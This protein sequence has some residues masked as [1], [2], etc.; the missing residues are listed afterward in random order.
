MQQLSPIGRSVIEHF[1]RQRTRLPD[2]FHLDVSPEDEMY[3]YHVSDAPLGD[4]DDWLLNYFESGSMMIEELRPIFNHV[5]GGF[6]KIGSLLEFACGHGRFTRYLVQELAPERIS[7]S[8]IYTDAVEFQ[9][10]EFGVRGIVSA[11]E[12][13]EF[14]DDHRYECILVC[15]L[16]SHLPE[17]TFHLWLEKLLSLLTDD[18]FLIFT[19]H[20]EAVGP[21][22]LKNKPAKDKPRITFSPISESRSLDKNVYGTTFVNEA[23]CRDAIERASN[24][25]ASYARK[26]KGLWRYQDVY[27]VSK[28]NPETLSSL[29]IEPGLE[30]FLEQ[31]S[32]ADGRY[33]LS[34]WAHDFRTGEEIERVE[35]LKDGER[36]QICIPSN[37]RP[38]VAAHFDNAETMRSGW[39][40]IVDDSRLSDSSILSVRIT[41]STGESRVIAFNSVASLC[42]LLNR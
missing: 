11:N 29:N 8:D 25:L 17:R 33:T 4:V 41:S 39:A 38:D 26:P 12:P 1:V 14:K 5:Y 10:K 2:R 34:G 32:S 27:V 7:V 20:D 22:T 37:D 6:D 28:Q 13:S 9:Q 30:G 35:V 42:H 31:C 18:G 24:G 3:L 16:F 19:V 40:C 36:L 23:F 21:T 15:S